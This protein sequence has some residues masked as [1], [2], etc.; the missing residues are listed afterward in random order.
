MELSSFHPGLV[1]GHC[2]GVDPYY[3]THKAEQLG[4]HPE[5]V[6]AGRRINDGMSSWVA[7]QVVLELTRNKTPVSGANILILGFTFKEDCP[8][9]RNTKV[10]VWLSIC[11]SIQ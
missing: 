5:V 3:L 11:L 6:L 9:I 2:I 7:R 10:I 8:D 1:G 4:Y